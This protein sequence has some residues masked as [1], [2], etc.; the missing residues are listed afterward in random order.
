[1]ISE[2]ITSYFMYYVLFVIQILLKLS[3][4]ITKGRCFREKCHV[5]NYRF[6]GQYVGL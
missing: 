3:I 6:Y 2:C 4:F 1:M 5:S